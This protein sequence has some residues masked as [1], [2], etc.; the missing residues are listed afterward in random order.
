MNLPDELA[1]RL[2]NVLER[3]E[4]KLPEP[5]IKPVPRKRVKES[6][7]EKQ[8]RLSKYLRTGKINGKD[9]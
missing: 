4:S 2:I 9:I 8:H 3:M 5:K 1:I 6:R 7:Q